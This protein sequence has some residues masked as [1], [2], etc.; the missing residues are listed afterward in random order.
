ML[1]MDYTNQRQSHPDY[2][3]PVGFDPGIIREFFPP[4]MMDLLRLQVAQ[5][6]HNPEI[7][8]V[9]GDFNRKQVHNQPLFRALQILMVPRLEELLERPLLATYSFVSIYEAGKGKCPKHIDRPQCRYTLDLC[10]DQKIPWAFHAKTED[11]RERRFSMNPG[12]A[13]LL[14][15]TH[16]EHWRPDMQLDNFCDLAFFHF[17]DKDFTGDLN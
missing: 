16:H 17:V 12:D 7:V 1:A 9:G 2:S 13:I 6:K 15:G 3:R 4:V 5:I 11:G 10:I 8:Y 14:S